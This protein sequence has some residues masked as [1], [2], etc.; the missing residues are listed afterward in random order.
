MS[1]KY[2]NKKQILEEEKMNRINIIT[3]GVKDI[4]K[5]L[6]F[7][8]DG[9]GFKTSVNDDNPSIVYFDNAGTKLAL[10]PLDELAKDI[11]EAEPPKGNGFSSITF[12]YVAKSI[13]EVDEIMKKAEKAG[14]KIEKH[15]QRVFWGGYSGYF[16]DPDGYYWEVAYAEDWNFDEND[17]VM[18]E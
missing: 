12:A 6:R 10:Y 14:A 18:V 4:G 8:R 16:S 1:S 3:L 11:N 5:S 2:V 15:P 17:M 13:E 7:Y 9:L